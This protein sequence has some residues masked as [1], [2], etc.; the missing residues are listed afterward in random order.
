[1]TIITHL[2]PK[3]EART[4]ALVSLVATCRLQL[5]APSSRSAAVLITLLLERNAERGD[6]IPKQRMEGRNL[7]IRESLMFYNGILGGG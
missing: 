7:F 6:V 2:A 4:R 3:L 5:D 1:M